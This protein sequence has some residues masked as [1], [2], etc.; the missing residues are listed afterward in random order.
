[1]A[2]DDLNSIELDGNSTD[3]NSLSVIK[4]QEDQPVRMGILVTAIGI[5]MFMSALDESII[6]IGI[7]TIADAFEVVKLRAQWAVLVYLLIIVGLTAAAGH[8]G[9]RFS[10][11]LVFQIGIIIFSLGSLICALSFNLPMLVGARMF[12]AIGAAGVLANGNAI[13]TRFTG[14]EKRGL[15]IGLTA[16]VSALGVVVGPGIGGVMINYWGWQSVFW[17]NVPIGVIGFIYV[18]FAI[19]ATS[20][21][22]KGHK[23]DPFGSII[24]AV[25]MTLFVVSI[26]LLVETEIARPY[27]WSGLS[28]ALSILLL[29]GFIFWE[30]RFDYPFID[31][32]LFKNRKF[33]IGIFCALATYIALNS[34]A[35]QLPFY[36]NDILNYSTI[37]IALVIV[38]VP[39]GL[40]ITAPISGKISSKIDSRILSSFGLGLIL[41]S[42]LVGALLVSFSTPLWF[43]V[44]IATIIGLAIGIFT[45]PNSNSVMS[46]VPKDA[47]GVV[48]GF[49]QLSRNIGY[50]IGTALSTTVFYII[51]DLVMKST[52]ISDTLAEENYVLT[53]KILFGLLCV[54]VAIAIILSVLRGPELWLENNQNDDS[55]ED[56]EVTN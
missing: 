26:T 8:L 6:T 14:E 55:L 53:I 17:I 9:D 52:G 25:F 32:K 42:L 21:L 41:T 44:L 5:G 7:P 39:I 50:T 11:K 40:A 31:L 38:G 29:I 12:Q 36:M 30:R 2:R 47:L 27:L 1:M 24:F 23:G 34:V 35:F 15:A 51:L 37:K 54:F 18:Q 13:V 19:P 28:F 22:E 49:L 10:T 43:Y 3:A 56:K 46:S 16:L 45:S 33:T 48:S 20:S 4:D